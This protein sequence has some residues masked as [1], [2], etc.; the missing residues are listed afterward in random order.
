M[1]GPPGHATLPA[2]SQRFAHGVVV[3]GVPRRSIA[4]SARGTVLL[5]RAEADSWGVGLYGFGL[6]G[7]R[8]PD[9][10][11][12]CAQAGAFTR[13][14][15]LA[16][17]GVD[18]T[19]VLSTT[20]AAEFCFDWLLRELLT[21]VAEA[22][23]R[24]ANFEARRRWCSA[25]W[26]SPKV[27]GPDRSG[28]VSVVPHTCARGPSCQPARRTCQRAGRTGRSSRTASSHALVDGGRASARRG[29]CQV[30]ERGHM[31]GQTLPALDTGNGEDTQGGK[32]LDL[33]DILHILAKVFALVAR[34]IL[35]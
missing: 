13:S 11:G 33:N 9:L 30:L 5:P 12:W 22:W 24:C 18:S 4:P 28:P 35:A 26:C 31:R 32:I 27:D 34:G 19:K 10:R 8:L 7:Q 29:C 21:A 6:K 17:P 23:L 20:T 25:C 1:E 2:D 14:P 3:G 16:E 15:Q